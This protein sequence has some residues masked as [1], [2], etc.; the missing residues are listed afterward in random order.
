MKDHKTI[1][2][3]W[4]ELK[5]AAEYMEVKEWQ[6]LRAIQESGTND[7]N[8]VYAW[9]LSFRP[10]ENY[11]TPTTQTKEADNRNDTDSSVKSE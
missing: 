6:V 8:K 2:T 9:V 4:H 3:E 5:H 7:R 10:D 11:E 1:S